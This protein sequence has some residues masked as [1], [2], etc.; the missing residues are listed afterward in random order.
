LVLRQ[1]PWHFVDSQV[2]SVESKVV[3]AEVSD[4]LYE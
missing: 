1:E 3:G 4:G 2:V